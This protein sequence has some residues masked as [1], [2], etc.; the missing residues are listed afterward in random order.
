MVVALHDDA[1]AV[2]VG[3]DDDVWRH[4][5]VAQERGHSEDAVLA[6]GRVEVVIRNAWED[7]DGRREIVDAG[8]VEL[9]H[10][11][12]D[13]HKAVDLTRVDLV[14]HGY[15]EDAVGVG[16]VGDDLVAVG[17]LDLGDLL[18]VLALYP[19]H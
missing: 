11:D 16:V 19:Q 2:G 15:F 13:V 9:E 7:V 10:A 6:L 12:D 18:H 1:L 3:A 4:Y 8:V 14:A 5:D 17:E